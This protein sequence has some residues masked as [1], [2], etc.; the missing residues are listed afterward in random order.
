MKS[1]PLAYYIEHAD[2]LLEEVL[3]AGNQWSGLGAN[4]TADFK[5]LEVAAQEYRTA[6]QVADDFRRMRSLVG[7]EPVP[8]VETLLEP[9][10]SRERATREAFAKACQEFDGKHLNIETANAG[11]R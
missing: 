3:K 11:R 7:H 2:E 6:K 1:R 10:F 9:A 4:F 8:G 5:A